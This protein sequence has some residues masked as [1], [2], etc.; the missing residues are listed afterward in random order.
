MHTRKFHIIVCCLLLAFSSKGQKLS[1]FNF[2]SA[3]KVAAINHKDDTAYFR[4]CYNIAAE[5]IAMDLYDSAQVWLNYISDRLPLR[6]PSLFNFYISV[7]QSEM[8]YYSGLLVMDMQ[9]SERILRFAKALDD[10]ILLAT[11]YNFVGLA[12]MNLGNTRKAIPYF[13]TGMRYV[14]QPPYPSKYLSASQPHHIL[15]NMAE[16]YY[17]LGIYDSSKYYAFRAKDSATEI[18]S[19]RGMAV[20]NNQLGLV[21]Y[22]Q[23]KTDSAIYFQ[24]IAIAIGLQHREPDVSLVSM[25]AL[26]ACYHQKGINDS[27]ISILHRAFALFKDHPLINT[28]FTNLFLSDAIALYKKLGRK[29]DLIMAVEMKDSI[30]VSLMKRNDAQVATLVKAG[31]MNE[32]RAANL[33]LSE[34]KQKQ[35]ASNTRLLIALL[36]LGGMFVLFFV[37]RH[38]HNKQLT[39]IAI[40]NKISRDLHDDIGATLSSI[41]IFGE[42]AQHNIENRPGDSREMLGKITDQAKNLMGRMG[43]VIWSMKP[44]LDENNSIAGR[45]KNYGSELLA[46]QGISCQFEIDEAVANKITNPVVRKNILLIVK[47]AMNNIAKYSGA[48]KT[49]VSLLKQG[50]YIILSISDNGKGFPVTGTRQGNGL[51]NMHQ[52]CEDIGG[53]C[54]ILS[55]PGKGVNITCIFPMTIFS[56]KL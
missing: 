8:Y 3:A 19:Y 35:A 18:N 56:D 7:E 42:L 6:K 32:M 31:V 49:N 48:G 45:L 2:D 47:E 27:A 43:D 40:R 52:R 30:T 10:S 9:E 53:T 15:G 13:D 28:F 50:N 21:Y 12:N 16:G 54:K 4:T 46:P 1:T 25:G 36:V 11:G 5:Y 41:N 51:G 26:A 33:E 34:A 55:E 38:Y 37:Y 23:G 29:D 20:A 44:E 17:K 14:R 22:R 39:E 24:Q